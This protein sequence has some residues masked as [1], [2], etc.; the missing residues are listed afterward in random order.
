MSRSALSYENPVEVNARFSENS[1]D[2]EK[3]VSSAES[4][5]VPVLS[6]PFERSRLSGFA[7][8]A[9]SALLVLG[10]PA[11]LAHARDCTEVSRTCVDTK[12]HDETLG[13]G[14]HG[15]ENRSL[16]RVRDEDGCAR[17]DRKG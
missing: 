4:V 15:G 14:D 3:S 9:C 8:W 6:Q 17:A 12:L 13:P 2:F 16:D 5:P 7:G 11:G 10:L 1:E